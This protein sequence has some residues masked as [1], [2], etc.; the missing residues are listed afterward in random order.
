MQ[1][2]ITIK[3]E[4]FISYRFW[5]R[6]KARCK[7]PSG[8]VKA[9]RLGRE[10]DRTWGIYLYRVKWNLWDSQAEPGLVSSNQREQEFDKLPR[11]LM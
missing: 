8:E 6:F 5:R 11:G 3:I 4:N 7:G 9:G 10:C 1:K 2:R